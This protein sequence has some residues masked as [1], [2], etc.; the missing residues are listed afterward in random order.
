[1]FL[2]Q[3]KDILKPNYNTVDLFEVE[4]VD[5]DGGPRENDTSLFMVSSNF[6]IQLFDPSYDRL[7]S[8]LKTGTLILKLLNLN[9]CGAR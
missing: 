5:S 2:L 9:R 4:L 6:D 1:M 8:K 7:L 3:D